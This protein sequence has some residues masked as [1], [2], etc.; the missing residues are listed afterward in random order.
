MKHIPLGQNRYAIVDDEAFLRLSR[1]HYYVQAV[2]KPTVFIYRNIETPGASQSG[3]R[4]RISLARDV[5]GLTEGKSIYIRYLNGNRF[6]C[7][8]ENLFYSQGTVCRSN[9]PRHRRNPYR[10][11]ISINS[12]MYHLGYWPTERFAREIC[13]LAEAV[14]LQLRGKRLPVSHIRRALDEATGRRVTEKAA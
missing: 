13:K 4:P 10:V 7:R 6:D 3:N 11:A 9:Q 2:G 8:R 12:R 14:A 1:F 5:L